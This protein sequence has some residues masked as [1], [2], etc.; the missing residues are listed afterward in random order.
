MKKLLFISTLLLLGVSL[1]E[2]DERRAPSPSSKVVQ[3]VGL[4]DITVEYSRPSVK[5]REIFSASG[6]QAY[7]KM[8]RTGANSATKITFSDDVKVEN[9][10]LKAGSYTI[11][12]VPGESLWTVNLYPYEGS[13]WSAYREATPAISAEVKP[14]KLSSSVE[15]FLID[16]NDLRDYSATMYLVWESTA[17]PI[18]ITVK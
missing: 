14:E 9:L 10:D 7:G 8:W 13:R 12:S 11:I 4:T 15:S 2:Q 16:I 1:V 6:L 5:D 3:T 18:K 17:V